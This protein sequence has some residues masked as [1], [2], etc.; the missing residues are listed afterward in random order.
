MFEMVG[1]RDKRSWR[2]KER[3][4]HERSYA[5]Y[6]RFVDFSHKVI[7]LLG[8]IKQGN[9]KSEEVF[10]SI[11]TVCG[12]VVVQ[13]IVIPR[14]V[15]CMSR[16]MVGKT[17]SSIWKNK[18]GRWSCLVGSIMNEAGTQERFRQEQSIQESLACGW[19]MKQ[20]EQPRRKYRPW[21][22]RLKG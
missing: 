11:I 6:K 5:L 1:T 22:T 14:V 16:Y 2:N 3:K 8:A 21:G 7:D 12:R 4:A 10:S 19:Q 9:D 20:R 17:N 15:D 13:S 18:I